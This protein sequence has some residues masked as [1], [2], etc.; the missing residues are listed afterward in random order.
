[1]TKI[2]SVLE[3]EKSVLAKPL[4]LKS[5]LP[6]LH[7]WGPCDTYKAAAFAALRTKNALVTVTQHRHAK[8]FPESPRQIW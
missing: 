4:L 7:R 2:A 6:I 3:M 8:T 5:K 1:M